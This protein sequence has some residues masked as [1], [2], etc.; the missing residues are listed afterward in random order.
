MVVLVSEGDGGK[1]G[2][3]CWGKGEVPDAQ[4][5][6]RCGW[7]APPGAPGRARV[8]WGREQSSE[9]AV[10]RLPAPTGRTQQ[11]CQV[12]GSRASRPLR[13][14]EHRTCLLKLPQTPWRPMGTPAVPEAWP[15]QAG[16]PCTCRHPQAASRA[17]P[18]L[19][20][21]PS[22]SPAPPRLAGTGWDDGD[23]CRPLSLCRPRSLSTSHWTTSFH[24]WNR[25]PR[26]GTIH[27]P[28]RPLL[29]QPHGPH[30]PTV[31]PSLP[32]PVLEGAGIIADFGQ[33]PPQPP[34]PPR[35]LSKLPKFPL[36]SLPWVAPNPASLCIHHWP[37]QGPCRAPVCPLPGAGAGPG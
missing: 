26:S 27:A 8:C 33:D 11:S 12:C 25:V 29:A 5:G 23:A 28:G 24:A 1:Q 17:P 21:P 30:C 6:S 36:N 7:E 18:H 20:A 35:S 31:W 19:P 4:A 37:W 22:C 15:E 3:S 2:F 13:L 9:T 10:I 32:F 14:P 34:W 16:P